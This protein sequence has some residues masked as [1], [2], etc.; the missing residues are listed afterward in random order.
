MTAYPSLIE[1]LNG[2]RQDSA[3]TSHATI[4]RRH[5][6]NFA[7]LTTSISWQMYSGNTLTIVWH[8]LHDRCENFFEN[9]IESIV[10]IQDRIV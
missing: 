7:M 10:N 1:A 5:S 4:R 8:R 6:A 3:R 9:N 2:G